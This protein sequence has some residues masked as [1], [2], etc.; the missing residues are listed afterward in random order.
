MVTASRS[1][2]AAKPPAEP[3]WKN[4]NKDKDTHPN[5]VINL[6][7]PKKEAGEVEV[8]AAEIATSDEAKKGVEGDEIDVADVPF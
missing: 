4:K 5:Y 6:S 3:A 7:E 8:E 2:S 1:S